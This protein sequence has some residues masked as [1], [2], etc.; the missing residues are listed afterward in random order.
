MAE[1]NIDEI[2]REILSEDKKVEEEGEEEILPSEELYECPICHHTV[3]E[4][5]QFC[6]YCYAVFDEKVD[7]KMLLETLI[8]KLKPMVKLASSEGVSVPGIKEDIA[9]AKKHAGMKNF[10]AGYAPLQRAYLS[11]MNALVDHFKK[12]LE[13][14][15]LVM[16]MNSDVR[17][18]YSKAEG[19]LEE[20][21]IDDFLTA[22]NEMKEKASKISKEMKAY[23]EKLEGVEHA[24]DI[25]KKFEIPVDKALGVVDTAKDI[26]DSKKYGD[27]VNVLDEALTPIKDDI[28]STMT[29]FLKVVKDKLLQETYKGKSAS[30]NVM[31]LIRE[32]KVYRDEGNYVKVLEKMDEINRELSK[33]N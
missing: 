17:E 9:Q 30:R 1:E 27:A 13:K 23:L 22:M 11:V 4:D 20:W 25:A 31:R 3:S 5:A 24:I 32:L 7:Y 26:A 19:Y 16:G 28:E 8:G 6:P 12:E 2:I 33:E 14:Y 10:E 29:A 15:E 18:L 21:E